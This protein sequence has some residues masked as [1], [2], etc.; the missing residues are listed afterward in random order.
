MQTCGRLLRSKAAD[1][2]AA[3][4]EQGIKHDA[5]LRQL[6]AEISILQM[7][8][9]RSDGK[10][11]WGDEDPP[12]RPRSLATDYVPKLSYLSQERQPIHWTAVGVVA[13]LFLSYAWWSAPGISEFSDKLRDEL[14][15]FATPQEAAYVIVYW[16]QRG[17]LLNPNLRALNILLQ[18]PTVIVVLTVALFFHGGAWHPAVRRVGRFD[19]ACGMIARSLGLSQ[20]SQPAFF[21]HLRVS[22]SCP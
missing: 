22:Q 15:L 18:I 14:S 8:I 19:H 4:A 1:L 9:V 10:Q 13:F 16:V 17:L 5:E 3:L 6:R 2:R 12:Y 11:S 7:Q 20:S 21:W